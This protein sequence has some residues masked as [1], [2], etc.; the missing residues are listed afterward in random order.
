MSAQSFSEL[1]K[2]DKDT[3]IPLSV[4]KTEEPQQYHIMKTDE[5]KRLIFGWASVAIRVGG[6]QVVDLQK[7][8]IDPEDLEEAVYDYVLDFRDGGEEHIPGLRKKAR[9]VESVVFTKEKMRAM[10]IP[11]GTVPEGW[12]IGFFV[13][14]DEAWEKVKNGTYQMFSIEGQGV[15]ENVEDFAKNDKINGCGVLV[16]K[17]GKILTGTRIGGK[18]KGQ[19]C[20]PGGHIESGESHEEAAIREAHE[21]FGIECKELEPLGILDG[22]RNY[23]KSAVFLCTEYDGTPETDEEEMTDIKWRTIDELR[24]E[25]LFWPFEQ[26]LDMLEEALAELAEEMSPE[27]RQNVAKTF[28]EILK[29][30]PFHDALGRFAS[31]SGFKTYSANPKTKAGAMAINRSFA[32]GHGT[33]MNVHR[34]SKGENINQNAHWLAT[35]QKPAV[36]AAQAK[37]APAK[38]AT[39][40]VNRDKL[41]FAD[42]DA[43]DYHQLGNRKKYYQQQQLTNTQKKSVDNYLEAH[44]E[45]GSLYSHSQNLNMKMVTGQ[46][47]TGKYKQ[48]YDGL[49]SSMHNLGINA[50]LTRYDHPNMINNMLKAAG[51]GSDYT[52]MNLNTIKQSLVGKTMNENKFL[53]CSTNDFQNAPASSKAVFTNRAVKVTYRAKA[54]VKA[55]MPGHGPGGD[56]GEMILAPTNGTNNRGGKIVDVKFTGKKARQKGTQTFNMKQIEIVVEI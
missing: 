2:F 45:P 41:G 12:W 28:D 35:G 31:S 19:I 20:G 38:P 51:A 36:P 42:Y 25:K 18:H 14:D 40:K 53:S 24:E 48:T 26:S 46:N 21:E 50:E 5:D 49:M 8:L 4:E 39:P 9:L 6:E 43:A 44:T 37:P 32:G 11:E 7:D 17:D 52:K 55:M 22:G 30:N 1:I 54:D 15:R 34:E 29:F 33:T 3:T 10:G 27:K 23:G 16:V 47:L 56:L 13:D